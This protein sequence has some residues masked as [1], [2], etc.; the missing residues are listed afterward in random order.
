[1]TYPYGTDLFASADP[2]MS[3]VPR[4]T[5]PIGT[6]QQY[7]GDYRANEAGQAVNYPMKPG[8]AVGR[9]MGNDLFQ[10][11]GGMRDAAGPMQAR[12]ID[13]PSGWSLGS[14][15]GGAFG[16]GGKLAQAAP[17]IAQGAYGL[18]RMLSPDGEMRE[19]PAGAASFYESRGA[20]RA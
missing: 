10:I 20:R 18:V 13:G 15:I 6:P 14:A 1:M 11:A 3:G 19:V 7:M 16:A 9:P 4:S 5:M 8:A 2:R 17:A 12:K